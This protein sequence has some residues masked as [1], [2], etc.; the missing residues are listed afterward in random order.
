MASCFPDIWTWIQTLPP[1]TQWVS[2]S[3]SISIYSSNSTKASL[4]FSVTKTTQTH[5]PSVSFSMIVSYNMPISLWSSKS[6]KTNPQSPQ[7]LDDE[8]IRSLFYNFISST[9]NYGPT[10]NTTYLHIPPIDTI[11]RFKDIFNLTI[12]TLTLLICIYEAPYDLRMEWLNALENYLT[13]SH[14]KETTKTM[15]MLLGSNIEEQWMRSINLAVTNWIIELKASKSSLRTI[16]PLFSYAFSTFGLWKVQLYCP[17]IAMDIENSSETSPDDRL[18]LSLRYH[19]L[20]GVYQFIYRV[21]PREKWID[22]EVKV[23]NIR[24]DK[25]GA[26]TVEKHFPSRISLQMTPAFQTNVLSVTVSRSSE[27]PTRDIGTGMSIDA[28]FS[29]PTSLGLSVTASETQ[30]ISLKPWKFEQSVYGYS[31]N[32]NW[33]LHDSMDGREV[34]SSK[35]S[36]LAM[37]FPR[38]SWFKDRYTSATRPFT[39]QGGVIF[40][41]DEYGDGVVWKV[42]KGEMGKT[43][44]WEVKGWIWLTYWP[45][46]RRTFHN[47]TRKFEFREILSMSLA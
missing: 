24:C 13:T 7:I 9:L 12:F 17:I 44:E 38:G 45:N 41:R 1:V 46:K 15:M 22:V 4:K 6:F 27:N 43:M 32:M 11:S 35:P 18:K 19:Q 14:S 47:E 29:G 40:A 3:M 8:T 2:N 36:K 21:I 30:T 33:F 39:R 26:G 16:I 28:G 34:V 5:H 31:A 42:D 25:R 20:E 23:D 10:K 37:C